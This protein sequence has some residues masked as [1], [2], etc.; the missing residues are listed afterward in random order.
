MSCAIHTTVLPK[1]HGVRV[2]GVPIARDLIAREVQHH[3]ARTPAE[4]FKAAAQ[5]L[6]IRELLLQEARRLG[7][8][9]DPLTDGEGRREAP[10]EAM[11]RALVEQEVITPVPDAEACR[12]YFNNNRSRF[13][14]PDIVEAAHILFA[15]PRT[16][17][18]LYAQARAAAQA[19]LL[20]LQ[21]APERF[22][23]LARSHSACP[24][25]AQG[26]NL[27]QITMGQTTPE[28]EAALAAIAPGSIAAQPVETPYGC[29][30]VRVDRRIAGAELP[31]ELV[32]GRIAEYLKESVERRA[33]AQYIARLAACATIEGVALASPEELQVH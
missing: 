33:T 29:H 9:A 15:A 10:E 11:I 18:G 1:G 17:A 7:V 8:S 12:R 20:V 30:V 4:A 13:R 25:A 19:V 28:F 23:E 16:N 24:S 22:A 27:G 6:V 32:A 31:F 3:P 2:N 14:S 21:A 5:S 26:G